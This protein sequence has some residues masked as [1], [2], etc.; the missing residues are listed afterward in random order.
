MAAV[1]LG[2]V[3]KGVAAFMTAQHYKVI[4]GFEAY[5]PSYRK[6]APSRLAAPAG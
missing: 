6:S 3:R 2:R 1:N 4:P 5:R